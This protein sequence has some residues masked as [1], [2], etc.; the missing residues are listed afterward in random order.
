M[1]KYTWIAMFTV[2]LSCNQKKNNEAN[3][4]TDTTIV[5]H[6][7]DTTSVKTDTHYFWGSS[8][9]TEKGLVMI[10]TLPLNKD[11]LTVPLIIGKLNKMYP[12][13]QLRYLKTSED[14]VVIYIDRS[15]YLTQ[16]MGSSG[17]QEYLAIVTFNLTE[18]PGINFVN[19]NFKAGDHASPGTYSRTDFIRL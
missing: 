9:D 16:S 15:S 12:E 10:K 4:E 19:L 17:A 3:V 11:S 1:K 14:S 6:N 2:L 5:F 18:I 7:S 13:I 8:W